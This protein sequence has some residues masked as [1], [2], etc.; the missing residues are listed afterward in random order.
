MSSLPNGV[1]TMRCRFLKCSNA[2]L[3]TILAVPEAKVK[4]LCNSR[5]RATLA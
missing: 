4:V 5:D 3:G 1:G 2:H